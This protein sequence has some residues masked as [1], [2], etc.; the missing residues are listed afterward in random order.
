MLLASKVYVD[1]LKKESI[2]KC[3]GGYMEGTISTILSEKCSQLVGFFSP[4]STYKREMDSEGPSTTQPF[5]RLL[6]VS[7]A[8]WCGVT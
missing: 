4:T 5:I 1:A 7:A 8:S 3:L 2:M 6:D